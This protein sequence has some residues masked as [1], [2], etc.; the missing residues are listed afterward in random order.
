MAQQKDCKVQVLK[1]GEC[2][3]SWSLILPSTKTLDGAFWTQLF[4]W[5]AGIWKGSTSSTSIHWPHREKKKSHCLCKWGS[6]Y[7]FNSYS[8][9]LWIKKRLQ[10]NLYK[11]MWSPSEKQLV[12]VVTFQI[13]W[14]YWPY[15][16]W[17]SR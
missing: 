2:A 8:R 15:W 12:F 5:W 7:I 11:L 13:K 1:L 3:K 10:S 4:P 9:L 14:V 16:V 17:F 6:T